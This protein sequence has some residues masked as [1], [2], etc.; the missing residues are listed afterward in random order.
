MAGTQISDGWEEELLAR[1]DEYADTRP[2]PGDPR[3]C[4]ALCPVDTGALRDS[5]ENHMNGHTLIVKATGSG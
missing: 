2:R 1:W 4:E 5:I 3:R